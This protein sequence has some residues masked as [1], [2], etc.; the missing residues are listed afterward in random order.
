MDRYRVPAASVSRHDP[1]QW[2]YG[3]PWLQGL[4]NGDLRGEL[5]RQRRDRWPHRRIIDSLPTTARKAPRRLRDRQITDASPKLRAIRL[6]RCVATAGR[7]SRPFRHRGRRRQSGL[8]IT[9]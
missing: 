6:R 5:Y 8:G 3:A 1:S 4:N 2:T 9:N 7:C